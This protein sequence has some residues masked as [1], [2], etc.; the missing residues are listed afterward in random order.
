M[1]ERI[2]IEFEKAKEVVSCLN[3]LPP[4]I[5]SMREFIAMHF[6]ELE[7]TGRSLES[8]HHFLSSKG[9]NVGTLNSF[10]STYSR[11]KRAREKD[12]TGTS[13]VKPVSDSK[14]PPKQPTEP[15]KT[16]PTKEEAKID[17]DI[18]PAVKR[19]C[20]LRPLT[21]PDGTPIEIDPETGAQIFK[22]Q[23]TRRPS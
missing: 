17:T 16:H 23:K 3:E 21:L 6:D 11:E 18:K 22:I 5:I 14:E 10:R 2:K 1:T 8:L 4:R 20:G 15:E 7:K 19:G 13:S 9:I 12:S